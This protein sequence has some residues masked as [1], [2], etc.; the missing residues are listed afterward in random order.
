[1]EIVYAQPYK[2]LLYC[3]YKK[4]LNCKFGH[5]DDNYFKIH[6]KHDFQLSDNVTNIHYI[7][8]KSNLY[9]VI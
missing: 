5:F 7:I 8:T 9:C 4:I 2:M 1:V 6:S 3:S